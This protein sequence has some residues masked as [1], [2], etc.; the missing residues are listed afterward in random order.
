MARNEVGIE[1]PAEV[2]TAAQQLG[3]VGGVRYVYR[4]GQYGRG[5]MPVA[6]I[7]CVQPRRWRSNRFEGWKVP[8]R[9]RLGHLPIAQRQRR[10]RAGCGGSGRRC[11]A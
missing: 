2:E 3:C 7:G 6:S 9:R 10:W 11:G 1:V 8:P 5:N 4:D